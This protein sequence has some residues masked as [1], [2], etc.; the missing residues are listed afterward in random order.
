MHRARVWRVLQVR[1]LI[2]STTLF[3]FVSSNLGIT[4]PQ[5]THLPTY[6][7]YG[8]CGSD[9]SHRDASICLAGYGLCSAPSCEPSSSLTMS[10]TLSA[11]TCAWAPA[12]S[13]CARFPAFLDAL[14][15]NTAF[16]VCGRR[17]AG[18]GYRVD[19]EMTV[20]SEVDQDALYQ[21]LNNVCMVVRQVCVAFTESLV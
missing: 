20:E 19:A 2:V 7:K 21:G 15:R 11:S 16:E 5:L 6:S 3:I 17:A 8:F 10:G 4:P 13:S 14:S 9:P 1:K 18:C 12:P